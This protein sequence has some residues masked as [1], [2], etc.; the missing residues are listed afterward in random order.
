MTNVLRT[1]MYSALAMILLLVPDP[2]HAQDLPG[3]TTHCQLNVARENEHFPPGVTINV[4]IDSAFTLDQQAA[5]AQA[6]TN[7]GA[8]GAM[9]GISWSIHY[10]I[11]PTGT[12]PGSYSHVVRRATPTSNVGASG[13]T[14]PTVPNGMPVTEQFTYQTTR[15]DPQVT[16]PAAVTATMAHEIG[17]TMGLED[18]ADER[19]GVPCCSGTSVMQGQYPDPNNPN[20]ADYNNLSGRPSGPTQC[21]ANNS[22]TRIEQDNPKEGEEESPGGG[23]DPSLVESTGGYTYC[24]IQYTWSCNY[25][26]T[27]CYVLSTKVLRCY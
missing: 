12:G 26:Y 27:D 22:A 1:L 10:G 15:I 21:D 16:N 5:V 9:S 8:A 6:F 7:W 23:G 20:Q 17:H 18:C 4:Y 14:G 24:D 2:M 19:G 11:P 25:N 13:E 3:C